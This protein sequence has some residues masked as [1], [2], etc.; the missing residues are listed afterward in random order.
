MV[1][2]S[3]SRPLVDAMRAREDQEL[4]KELLRCS[5]SAI[6]MNH[7]SHSK[8]GFGFAA[9]VRLKRQI[10]TSGAF[11]SVT[12]MN[13]AIKPRASWPRAPPAARLHR[14]KT[15]RPYPYVFVLLARISICQSLHSAGTIIDGI[16][17]RRRDAMVVLRRG[18][19]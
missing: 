16:L 6:D 3:L 4:P 18:E 8:T 12:S 17:Q 9:A 13:A 14:K 15:A 11:T 1:S 19:E 10:A 7:E 5:A 2:G